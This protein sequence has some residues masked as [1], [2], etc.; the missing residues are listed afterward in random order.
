MLADAAQRAL[1]LVGVAAVAMA[2]GAG[3]AWVARG[4]YA[5]RAELK[6]ELAQ[7]RAGAVL[8]ASD[9]RN[10]REASAGY[11]VDAER[12]RALMAQLRS[13][14]N[15]ALQAPVACASGASAVALGDVPIPA[16]AVE[17]LRRA[18]GDAPAPDRAASR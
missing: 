11:Q 5:E 16:A 4:V 10:A 14:P 15:D 2:L 6:D 12:F 3:G 13:E 8:T 18:A 1:A 17:R 7:V 9:R